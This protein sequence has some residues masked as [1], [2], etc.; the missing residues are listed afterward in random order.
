M[1]P[2]TGDDREPTVTLDRG[3][4]LANYGKETYKFRS[5]GAVEGVVTSAM[6]WVSQ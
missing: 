5:A 3:Q 1:L 2:P 4:P 6:A